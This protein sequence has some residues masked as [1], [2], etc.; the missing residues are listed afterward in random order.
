MIDFAIET[1]MKVWHFQKTD[2]T[3]HIFFR[4]HLFSRSL[5]FN[6]SQ[7]LYVRTKYSLSAEFFMRI[8]LNC[9]F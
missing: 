6:I 9:T 2:K 7:G 1:H 3:I 5:S 4:H 8:L